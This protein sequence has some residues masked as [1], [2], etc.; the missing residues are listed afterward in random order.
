MDVGLR[1]GPVVVD[2][3]LLVGELVEGEEVGATVG[4]PVGSLTHANGYQ[5]IFTYPTFKYD[6]VLHKE[7]GY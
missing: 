7:S 4:A 6:P 5:M 3:G 2:V 1:V